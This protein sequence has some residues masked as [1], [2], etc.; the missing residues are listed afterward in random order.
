MKKI[1]TK[2]HG[3]LDYIMGLILVTSPW[4]FNY[5]HSYQYFIWI[6]F[7]LGNLIIIYTML[8]DFE[9][10]FAPVLSVK[11]HLAIDFLSGAFL[12]A[13]PWIFG[14][15]EIIFLPHVVLGAAQVLAALFTRTEYKVSIAD[16]R[17]PKVRTTSGTMP[18]IHEREKTG[19]EKR[20][21]RP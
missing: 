17:T 10:G 12:A 18:E 6:P 2:T 7:A 3:K 15:S 19:G 14:F 13:S 5:A 8:T 16:A 20:E 9:H 1:S 11:A 4:I 21:D